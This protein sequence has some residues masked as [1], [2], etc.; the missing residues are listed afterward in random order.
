MTDTQAQPF[1]GPLRYHAVRLFLAFVAGAYV[2]FRYEGV[3]RLPDEPYILCFNHPSWLDPIV[4]AASWPDRRRR[5]F[6]FGPREWDMSRGWRN[7]LIIWTRRGVHFKPHAA[8]VLDATRRA[9]AVL[10]AGGVLA[11]AG[12][13]RLSDLETEARPLEPG[14]A[15]F[16]QLSGATILPL[17]IVGT[18]WVR[19]GGTI[20]FR[21][22]RPIR[23][24]SVARGRA[25]VQEL[26][27]QIQDEL[28]VLLA[29][30]RGTPVPGPFGR[31]LSELFN[32]R[33]WPPE[34][35]GP[36]D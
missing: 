17:A 34:E 13:G 16:A 30:T 4:L 23:P 6:I 14:V 5:L 19:F 18:R 20:R 24:D 1:P 31:W 9:A 25:G 8:D 21:I 35:G 36:G 33:S 15:H 7:H 32:D 3:D 11:V 22:G 10:R 28:A 27:R 29:G 12:E 2:R 26:T